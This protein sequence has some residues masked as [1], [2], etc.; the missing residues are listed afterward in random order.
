M[1][2]QRINFDEFNRLVSKLARDITVSGWRPDYIVGITRGGLIPAVMLS[3]YFNVPCETLKISI[4]NPPKDNDCES[5]LW[6]PEDAF[7]YVPID[8]QDMVYYE[9]GIPAERIQYELER[10][11]NILVVD[12]IN[13][14]GDTIQWLINDWRSSCCP[15][16]PGWNTVW[17]Q[18]VRFAVVVDNSASGYKN[19]DYSAMG[20]NKIE[21][22]PWIDFPYESW[23]E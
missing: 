1:K 15:K 9:N 20:M 23:W 22:D 4:N 14:T 16:N 21:D 6:M 18:N 8:D 11:K 10:R 12:N 7:G 17:N 13:D 19:V 5:N 2:K 3:H